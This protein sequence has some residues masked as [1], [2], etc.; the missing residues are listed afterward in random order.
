MCEISPVADKGRVLE[1]LAREKEKGVKKSG[2]LKEI[3]IC[4]FHTTKDNSIPF[5]QSA[6]RTTTPIM[7]S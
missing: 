5:L 1:G 3:E 6:L 4:I 7:L 2:E